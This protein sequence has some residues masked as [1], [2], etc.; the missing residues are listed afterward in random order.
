MKETSKA[1]KASRERAG[2]KSTSIYLTDEQ[3]E[4]LDAF[5]KRVGAAGRG[6]AIAIAIAA[7]GRN[8]PDDDALI[9]MLRERLKG[10]G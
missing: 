10:R 2:A 6:E 7:Y 3:R 9:D 8:Q 4:A 5:K 1:V